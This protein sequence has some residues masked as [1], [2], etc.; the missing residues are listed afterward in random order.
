MQIPKSFSLK[1]AAVR[2]GYAFGKASP[3]FFED[4]F[5]LTS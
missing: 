4:V 3:L 1:A 2:E 5:L